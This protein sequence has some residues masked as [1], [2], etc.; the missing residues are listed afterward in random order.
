M[1]GYHVLDIAELLTPDDADEVYQGAR[2]DA[3]APEGDPARD[4]GT[5]YAP[6]GAPST[7]APTTGG[8]VVE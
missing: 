3:G 1:R 5:G 4:T 6:P 2:N 7:A 8:T